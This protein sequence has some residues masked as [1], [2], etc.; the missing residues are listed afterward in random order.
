MEPVPFQKHVANW[1]PSAAAI[2]KSISF[3]QVARVGLGD[4]HDVGDVLGRRQKD[5]QV[6]QQGEHPA[7]CWL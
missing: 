5:D 1:M 6:L 2:T 3:A 4:E 7:R